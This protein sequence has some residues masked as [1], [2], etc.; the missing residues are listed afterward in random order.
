MASMFPELPKS[1]AGGE[2][3]YLQWPPN[4]RN[5]EF[6]VRCSIFAAQRTVC[7]QGILNI[8]VGGGRGRTRLFPFLLNRPRLRRQHP[9][10]ET[11][12]CAHKHLRRVGEPIGLEEC[13]HFGIQQG[14]ATVEAIVVAVL[15]GEL[16]TG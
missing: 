6:L 13:D 16:E 15:A 11:A 4:L 10:Q 5:S 12:P 14:I 8:E 3:R 7:A 2:G 9:V 1:S